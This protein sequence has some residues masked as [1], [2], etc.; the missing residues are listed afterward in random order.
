MKCA[1]CK[2]GRTWECCYSGDCSNSI[3]DFSSNSNPD[4]VES[5]SDTVVE[6]ISSEPVRE[7][8][9]YKTDAALK[10]QQSTGRK[11]AAVMYP[12]DLEL[13]CEWS[14]K[15]NCGG[16]SFPI[17]GCLDNKQTDRHHGPDKN[18]L[19][20]EE[21]NVHRIC[22]TC[23]N[24]WHAKNDPDYVWGSIYSEHSPVEASPEEILLNDISWNGVELKK[25]KD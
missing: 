8:K 3:P 25:V 22:A 14:H 21:G 20:N 7:I 10:D 17:I 9:T 16:G 12:L 13:P 23:H 19:N 15:K 11:R 24:R 18:T 1:S 5:G 6:K 4:S 2:K